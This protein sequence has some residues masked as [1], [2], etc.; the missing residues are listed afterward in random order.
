VWHPDADLLALAAGR[1]SRLRVLIPV[2]AALGL[3]CTAA[4]AARPQITE[5]VARPG[6]TT[7]LIVDTSGSMAATDVEPDR[8]TAAVQAANRFLDRVPR[9]SPVG[10]VRFSEGATVEVPP[11]ADHDQ[12]RRALADLQP[13]GGTATST[14]ILSAI[15]ALQSATGRTDGADASL[16]GTRVVLL[17]DGKADPPEQDPTRASGEAARLG[18]QIS[19]IALG[20]EDAVVLS[21]DGVPIPV[22]P[23]PDALRDIATRTGGEFFAS[24]DAGELERLYAR[25]GES[26]GREERVRELAG[27]AA[28][29]AAL[30]L[31][32]AGALAWR[33]MPRSAVA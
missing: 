10:L 6:A 1:P 13:L 19:T 25:L 21:P 20:T 29:L 22:P 14:A 24:A 9:G 3:L 32:C 4:A 33:V 18:V 17:S 28:G 26:V 15:G 2:L 16:A 5:T 8:L 7:V 12:V 27:W 31:A 23:D 11:T 30:L